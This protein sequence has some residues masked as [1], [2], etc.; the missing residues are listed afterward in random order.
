MA[1]NTLQV[2]QKTAFLIFLAFVIICAPVLYAYITFSGLFFTASPDW[3]AAWL[4]P[5][6]VVSTVLALASV[7]LLRK[8]GAPWAAALGGFLCIAGLSMALILWYLPMMLTLTAQQQM[9]WPV[10]VASMERSGKDIK[11]DYPFSIDEIWQSFCA[12]SAE[13]YANLHKGQK[14]EVIG[15]GSQYG[16][17]IEGYKLAE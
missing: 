16:M 8:L 11:C 7:F 13:D 14:I 4:V 6:M 10:T 2:S 9:S 12:T 17:F 5:G 1:S 15:I 3:W